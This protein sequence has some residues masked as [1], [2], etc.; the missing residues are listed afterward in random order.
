MSTWQ[1]DK[2]HLAGCWWK[3]VAGL[4]LFT[5]R[6][7]GDCV[8]QCVGQPSARTH[9]VT[10]YRY[11]HLLQEVCRLNLAAIFRHWAPVVWCWKKERLNRQERKGFLKES[12]LKS[13]KMRVWRWA[14]E[15]Q[16]KVH[17]CSFY[18]ACAV[19]TRANSIFQ[20]AYFLCSMAPNMQII[21]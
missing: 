6:S 8:C 4:E 13:E 12:A 1:P 21:F 18:R 11:R 15:W 2:Q 10:S 5:E 20:F 14:R 7:V 9:L 16:N 3:L 17:C 19:I